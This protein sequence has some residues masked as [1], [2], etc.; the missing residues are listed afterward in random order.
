MI[1]Q[2]IQILWNVSIMQQNTTFYIL[3]NCMAFAILELNVLMI[4]FYFL[5]V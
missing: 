2:E 4:L 5:T 3:D 1:H